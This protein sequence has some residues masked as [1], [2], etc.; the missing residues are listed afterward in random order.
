ML[1]EDISVF[2]R[3]AHYGTF[4]VEGSLSES[5]NCVHIAHFFKIFVIP[6]SDFLNFV[7]CTETVK[8]VD[9]RNSALDC[10]KVS[11]CAEIH[12]L[13]GICFSEHCETCL[14]AGINVGMVTENVKC[15]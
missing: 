7:G 2:V 14:T 9:E 12:N 4:G 5:V 6:N 10:C 3:T 13:L 15:V 8:E 1:E 11:N